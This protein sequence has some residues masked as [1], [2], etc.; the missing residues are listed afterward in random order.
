MT[1]TKTSELETV[2]W[3]LGYGYGSGIGLLVL[4]ES[5]KVGLKHKENIALIENMQQALERGLSLTSA[6]KE[7]NKLCGDLIVALF[8]IGEKS[9]QMQ[10]TCQL[11]AKELRQRSEFYNTLIKAL[12]YP[13]FLLFATL[14]VFVVIAVFVIPEFADIYRE[15]NANLNFST[16]ALLSLSEILFS[17]YW[18]ILFC[19]LGI[20]GI[21]WIGLSRKAYRDSL[22]FHTPFVNTILKDYE[23]YR[24]FVGLHYLLK[25]Q[26]PFE[27]SLRIC[28]GLVS[29]TC[30]KHQLAFVLDSILR[31]IP[32]SESLL[33][34]EVEIANIGL[35]SSAEQSGALDQALGLN[36][37]FYKRRY[38]LALQ[39]ITILTE[40]A[41]TMCIGTLVAWIAFAIISPMW[42]MLLIAV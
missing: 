8:E 7:H 40:P 41:A 4:L 6:F 26:V 3:Q 29:N 12:I 10:E 22:L 15:L 5:I 35:L 24:Y 14:I 36:A 31:G 11:C 1:P 32:F 42:D 9:G 25:S 27:E 39:Y 28:N 20:I 18:Q 34:S 33:E 13:C 38:Q 17:Y 37:E 2:F 30:M 23:L 16:K 19:I 21:C